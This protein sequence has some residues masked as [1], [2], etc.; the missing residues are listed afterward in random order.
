MLM[1]RSKGYYK[2]RRHIRA[3]GVIAPGLA[4]LGV[5]SFAQIEN[6]VAPS[7]SV[8]RLALDLSKLSQEVRSM[9]C[10]LVMANGSGHH[11]A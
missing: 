9:V 2:V 4:E 11:L 1:R 10:T 3:H 8:G 7:T 5:T 6:G